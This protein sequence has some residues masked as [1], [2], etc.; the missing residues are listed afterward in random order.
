MGRRDSFR[1]TIL[2]WSERPYREEMLVPTVLLVLCWYHVFVPPPAGLCCVRDFWN[3]AF[4]QCERMD[5][6]VLMG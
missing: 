2:V 5:R 4:C 1:R 3:G 6:G